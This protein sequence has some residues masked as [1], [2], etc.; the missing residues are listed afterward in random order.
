MVLREGPGGMVVELGRRSEI[1]GDEGMVSGCVSVPR[2][3]LDTVA[4]G[5]GNGGGVVVGEIAPS[6]TR[7][8]VMVVLSRVKGGR[9]RGNPVSGVCNDVVFG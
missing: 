2:M 6:V 9:G 8:K 3:P 1:S 7:E 5:N 4:F